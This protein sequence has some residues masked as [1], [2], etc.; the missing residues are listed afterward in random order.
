MGYKIRYKSSV[1]RDLKNLD[2]SVVMRILESI[3]K[4]LSENP[5]IGKPLTGKYKVLYK[6]R[7]G[8]YRVIYTIRGD[9][10]WILKIGHRKHVYRS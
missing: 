1:R 9:E 10:V 3:E 5:Y 4:N 6:Y 8:K 2:K 7:V